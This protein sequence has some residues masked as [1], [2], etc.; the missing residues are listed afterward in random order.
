MPFKL[1]TD[2][3]ELGWSINSSPHE[4]SNFSLW[5][6]DFK[7]QLNWIDKT[8]G[9]KTWKTDKKIKS[10]HE[11]WFLVFSLLTSSTISIYF[12]HLILKIYFLKLDSFDNP[13][14]IMWNI[15]SKMI[16]PELTNDTRIK[17]HLKYILTTMLNYNALILTYYW[18]Y[19]SMIFYTQISFSLFLLKIVQRNIR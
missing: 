10:S 16:I 6:Q 18:T 5:I 3:I 11:F 12:K 14:K 19:T 8:I 17:W 4:K 1:W 9:L 7:V 2:S 13:A 15:S